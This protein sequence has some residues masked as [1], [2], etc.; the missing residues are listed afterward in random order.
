MMT[1]MTVMIMVI[2][3]VAPIIIEHNFHS[4]ALLFEEKVIFAVF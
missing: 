1:V 3:I 4:G 2:M